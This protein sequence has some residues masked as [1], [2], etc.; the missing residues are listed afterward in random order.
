[1]R[2]KKPFTLAV[3][4][5]LSPIAF[6]QISDP[7]GNNTGSR[8]GTTPPAISGAQMPAIQPGTPPSPT[9]GR[10]NS[11]PA[12][13]RTGSHIS[14]QESNVEHYGN[15]KRGPQSGTRTPSGEATP[16]GE[17]CGNEG[18][19]PRGTLSGGASSYM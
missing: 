8:N 14:G 17:T 5:A 9:V 2:Y 1:M 11:D 4:L 19:V 10:S 15:R 13:A 16:R 7:T 3:L 18:N 6:A 12:A